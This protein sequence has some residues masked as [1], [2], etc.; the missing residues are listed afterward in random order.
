MKIAIAAGGVVIASYFAMR[1][2]I[3]T[4]LSFWF[5]ENMIYVA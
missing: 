3:S 2:F 1:N 5:F 4:R